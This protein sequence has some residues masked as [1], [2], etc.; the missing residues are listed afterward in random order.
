MKHSNEIALFKINTTCIIMTQVVYQY[1]TVF[2]ISKEKEMDI[3]R[4]RTEAFLT[5][6]EFAKEMG[7][8]I[9]TVRAWEHGRFNPSLK[10]QKKIVDFCKKNG[11]AV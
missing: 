9:E 1:D 5:Q 4:I 10:A 11:I 6:G 8:H 7:V 3:K 2:L